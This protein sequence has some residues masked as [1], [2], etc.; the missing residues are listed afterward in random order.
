MTNQKDSDAKITIYDKINV[1]RQ[2]Y[3]VKAI[4]KSIIF[5]MN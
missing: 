1:F 2:C 3:I 4:G 5:M